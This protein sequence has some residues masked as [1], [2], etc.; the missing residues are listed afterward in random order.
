MFGGSHTPRECRCL[1]IDCDK[2]VFC[3]W[4]A[5]GLLAEQ[6]LVVGCSRSSRGVGGVP[7]G[8]RSS[9]LV[10]VSRAAA[11]RGRQHSGGAGPADTMC[12]T[13][14][15]RSV[16]EPERAVCAS[17]SAQAPGA[18]SHARTRWRA[19]CAEVPRVP[20]TGISASGVLGV[21][22]R[23]LHPPRADLALCSLIYSPSHGPTSHAQTLVLCT[24][25]PRNSRAGARRETVPAQDG[26]SV[27][28]RDQPESWVC[29]L[30]H[31]QLL[32]ERGQDLEEG[33]PAVASERWP[34]A[35]D[36]L[37]AASTITAGGKR[38][39]SEA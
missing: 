10:S 38:S 5:H 37:H 32:R 1:G 7:V 8:A 24:F 12:C 20:R 11:D 21:A 22:A 2:L 16:C 27:P 9:R 19:Q 33:R 14:V 18:D 13:A 6:Q 17:S 25:C 31:G 26:L 39:A 28:P 29:H 30:H 4:Q 36:N 23:A 15:A 34:L 35:A 3:I